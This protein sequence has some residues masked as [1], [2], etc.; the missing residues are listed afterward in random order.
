MAKCIRVLTCGLRVGQRCGAK[1]INSSEYCAKCLLRVR[2]NAGSPFPNKGKTWTES[3]SE[4]LLDL[5]TGKVPVLDIS[6]KL[7]RSIC[8]IKCKAATFAARDFLTAC[9]ES[10]EPFYICAPRIMEEVN[11]QYQLDG[12]YLRSA[13][14]KM[15]PHEILVELKLVPHT[16]NEVQNNMRSSELL[17]RLGLLKKYKPEQTK[18]ET[19][20]PTE[21]QQV[22]DAPDETVADE[23]TAEPHPISEEPKVLEETRETPVEEKPVS[24][25]DVVKKEDLDDSL[26]ALETRLGC[27][28]ARVNTLINEELD[29]VLSALEN[30]LE[31]RLDRMNNAINNRADQVPAIMERFSALEARVSALLSV[32]GH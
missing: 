27:R 12:L 18:V 16:S 13:L 32:F 10:D 11:N 5:L 30:R 6:V 3:E 19:S 9:A 29:V 2:A 8:A 24:N 20:S 28:I 31:S 17:I 4:T 15:S 1:T 21:S 14:T 26:E 25:T 23:S 7:G 22:D